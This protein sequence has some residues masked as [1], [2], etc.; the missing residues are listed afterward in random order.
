MSEQQRPNPAET[1]ASYFGPTIADPWTRVLLEYAA[2]QPG[3]RVLDLAC[4]TGSVA[5]RLAPLVGAEGKI[6]ALDVNP[7]MLAVGRSLAAPTGATIEWREG[8]AVALGLPD[9]AFDL[10]VCQQGLQFFSDRA[11]SLR[12]MRRVLADG[13]RAVLSVWQ[14]LPL[15]PVYEALFEATA[16][17]LGANLADVAL[18]FSLG[19]AEELR[20]L[21]N[22]AGFQPVE[23]VPRSLDVHLP[24]PERFVQLTVLGA[25]TSVPTFAQL[26]AA[27]RSALVESVSRE[28][29]AV[30]QRYH[31]GNKLTFPMFSHLAVASANR[32]A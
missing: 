4:G 7:D 3:Q 1:Y 32:L 9:E 24:S 17:R 20:A 19:D 10:V 31:D 27:G 25:A 2:A 8:D 28:V 16:R 30:A 14:A 6:V 18:P 23:V 15:H 26:D 13:G 5:R 22:G 11:A 12:E 21:L 29:E